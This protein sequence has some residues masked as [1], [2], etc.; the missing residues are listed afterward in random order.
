[1]IASRVLATV[2]ELVIGLYLLNQVYLGIWF[3][4]PCTSWARE[5]CSVMRF[6]ILLRME[7]Q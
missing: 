1:M 3:R 2:L 4:I 6:F 7:I 5:V